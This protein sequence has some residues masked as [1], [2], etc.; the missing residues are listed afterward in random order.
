MLHMVLLITNTIYY[1]DCR[2]NIA[3]FEHTN[4]QHKCNYLVV[5]IIYFTGKQMKN[6]INRSKYHDSTIPH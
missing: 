4:T 3:S 2:M 5:P 1:C 6:R